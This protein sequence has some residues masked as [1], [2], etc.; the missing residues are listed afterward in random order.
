MEFWRYRMKQP[1]NPFQKTLKLCWLVFL[2]VFCPVGSLLEEAE[3]GLFSSEE[4]K[5][6]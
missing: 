4:E 3:K 1:L 6:S 2:S 5:S